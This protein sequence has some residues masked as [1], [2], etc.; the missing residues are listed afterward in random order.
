M[1]LV[2]AAAFRRA[3]AVAI[4]AAVGFAVYLDRSRMARGKVCLARVEQAMMG[5][6]EP[7]KPPLDYV[8]AFDAKLT[9]EDREM[10]WCFS[11]EGG[12]DPTDD[13]EA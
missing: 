13:D 2:H 4:G 7:L 6:R 8:K 5:E 1:P 10:L 12:V 9:R 11:I 3:R